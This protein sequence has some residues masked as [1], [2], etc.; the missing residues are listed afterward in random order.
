MESKKCTHP[1]IYRVELDTYIMWCAKCGGHR[2][3]SYSGDYKWFL[4]CG[5]LPTNKKKLRDII[6]SQYKPK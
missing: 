2:R 6:L 3:E 4:P 5:E 1:M